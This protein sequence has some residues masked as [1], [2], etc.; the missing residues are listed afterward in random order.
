VSVTLLANRFVSDVPGCSQMVDSVGTDLALSNGLK[1]FTGA[2]YVPAVAAAWNQAFSHAQYVILTDS[3]KRRIAWTPAL[4]AYLNDHFTQVYRS[5]RKLM[6][7][8][9]KGLRVP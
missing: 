6:L 5:P 4:H 3:N 1:P 2:G 9:R 8:V 7:Y